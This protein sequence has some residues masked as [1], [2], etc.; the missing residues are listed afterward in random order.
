MKFLHP[1][2]ITTI[3]IVDV[4]IYY[5]ILLSIIINNTVDNIIVQ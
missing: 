3:S 5:I 4:P 1:S 2:T